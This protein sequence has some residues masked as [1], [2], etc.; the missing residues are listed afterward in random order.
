MPLRAS[1]VVKGPSMELELEVDQRKDKPC[2]AKA[3][4]DVYRA[5]HP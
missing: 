5:G 1:S 3:L 2:V 4:K